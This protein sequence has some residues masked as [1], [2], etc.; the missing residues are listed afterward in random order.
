MSD[1]INIV[2]SSVHKELDKINNTY[3]MKNLSIEL[4]NFF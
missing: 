3:L 2:K 4:N 1:F